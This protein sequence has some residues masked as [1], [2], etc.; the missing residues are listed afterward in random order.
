MKLLTDTGTDV[1]VH[2]EI[3]ASVLSV[4]FKSGHIEPVIF[5]M[6]NRPM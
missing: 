3:H 4:V 1:N 2:V 6:E 5:L